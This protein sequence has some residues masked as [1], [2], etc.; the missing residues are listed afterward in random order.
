MAVC[1]GLL[2]EELCHPLRPMCQEQDALILACQSVEG[3]FVPQGQNCQRLTER[4]TCPDWVE[5]SG[6]T[7]TDERLEEFLS[8]WSVLSFLVEVGSTDAACCSQEVLFT[9]AFI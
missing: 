4:G 6:V 1:S 5:A 9:L 2:N 3:I 7:V 8:G